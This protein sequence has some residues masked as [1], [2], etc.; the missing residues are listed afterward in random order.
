MSENLI[1]DDAIIVDN[2]DDESNTNEPIWYIYDLDTGYSNMS[3][4]NEDYFNEF[5]MPEGKGYV[6][7]NK[8]D[9][10]E[11]KKEMLKDYTYRLCVDLETKKLVI[12]YA[13]I[14]KS[15]ED[16]KQELREAALE[17]IGSGDAIIAT[18]KDIETVKLEM[19][20]TLA[21]AISS[22]LSEQ[23]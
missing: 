23:Q 6:K 18:D 14:V 16:I 8:R 21:E 10:P 13:K 17:K 1:Y 19:E 12:K 3:I 9:V 22:M 15:E 4:H 11:P 2:F 7:V 20:Q 5:K